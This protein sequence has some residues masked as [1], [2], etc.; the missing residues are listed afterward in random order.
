LKAA[1]RALLEGDEARI[2]ALVQRMAARAGG[3]PPTALAGRAALVARLAASY[4]ADVGVF[5]SLLLNFIRLAPGE[6]VYLG[7]NQPHAYLLGDCIEVSAPPPLL[8]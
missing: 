8:R 6:G 1:L 3:A 4:P 7:A 5:C 2:G